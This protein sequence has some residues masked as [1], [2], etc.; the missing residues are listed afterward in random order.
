M[1]KKIIIT[2]P[3]PPG[4]NNYKKY[5]VMF[6][7]GRPIA[8]PYLTKQATDFKQYAIFKLK[9]AAKNKNWETPDKDKYIA[10]RLKFY[11]NK[12]GKDA[13]N[14]IKLIQDAIQD[15]GLVE[16]DSKLIPIVERLYVDSNDP[17][18]KIYLHE[19][20]WIGIF[21]NKNDRDFFINENCINCKRYKR[22]CSILKSLD[23]NKIVSEVDFVQGI[24]KK[25]SNLTEQNK[26]KTI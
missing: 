8:T 2:L 11:M 21:D 5:K 23:E 7:G 25:N 13:D 14:H 16:N 22:N 4:V 15:A 24:C 12:L 10:M 20:D 19:L 18:V 3:L 1:N 9:E 17:R 26:N 6:Q